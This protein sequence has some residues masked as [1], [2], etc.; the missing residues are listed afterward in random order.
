MV[1]DRKVKTVVCDKVECE[2]SCV[3]KKDGVCV[4]DKAVLERWC[5]CVCESCV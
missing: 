5:A 1:K 4:C 3:T 2:R